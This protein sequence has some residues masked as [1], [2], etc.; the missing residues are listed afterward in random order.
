MEKAF[1]RLVYRQIIDN[2]A[3]SDFER[4]VFEDSF[5]E[6][7]L[8]AQAYNTEN[9]LGTLAELIA[10]N[11]KANS[12]H[13]KTGF[14]IGLYVGALHKKIPFLLDALGDELLFEEHRFKILYS[15][16]R[17][18]SLHMVAVD[19]ITPRLLLHREILGCLLLSAITDK[20]NAPG[21]PFLLPLRNGLSI[22]YYEP[23]ENPVL[24]E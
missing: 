21:E 5:Q 24:F 4:A 7:T 19:Y 3:R 15:D 18:K 9:S 13:Y 8:Q 10:H 22:I 12:L 6:L 16:L 20:N 17:D 23:V 14:A 1:I 2:S 11:P